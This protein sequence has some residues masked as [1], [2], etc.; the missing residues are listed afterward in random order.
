M[1]YWWETEPWARDWAIGTTDSKMDIY[2]QAY[3]YQGEA[4]RVQF[5]VSCSLRADMN[6]AWLAAATKLWSDPAVTP[7]ALFVRE[8]PDEVAGVTVWH[9]EFA[10]ISHGSPF[11]VLLVVAIVLAVGAALALA[12]PSLFDAALERVEYFVD[13][14]TTVISQAISGLARGATEPV[15]EFVQRAANTVA[16]A[17]KKLGTGLAVGILPLVLI[18]GGVFLL[19]AWGGPKLAPAI[20]EARGG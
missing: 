17:S 10:T 16:D 14:I 1:A 18:A 12:A 4:D 8:R 20:K 6:Q 15:L 9:Y 3:E 7:L 19:L 11:P 13:R 2:P 5:T